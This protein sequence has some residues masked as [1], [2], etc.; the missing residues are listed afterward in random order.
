MTHTLKDALDTF[1]QAIL[2][3]DAP[4]DLPIFT[5]KT[6]TN[7][8]VYRHNWLF[9]LLSALQRR[10]PSVEKVLQPNNFKFFA[11][12][13]IFAHPAR[14]SNIDN[15]GE[16]FADFLQLRQELQP[17]P[18]LSDIARLDDVYFRHDLHYY[19]HVSFGSVALWENI[20]AGTTPTDISI[21]PTQQ[22]RVSLI[23]DQDGNFCLQICET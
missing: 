20:Q 14:V 17:L 6:A 23:N 22:Q 16:S 9:G 3:H 12:E 2:Q 13:F 11:K 5:A 18:Y 10:Y 15:Y 4:H 8:K 21:D 1:G 19:V 7:L